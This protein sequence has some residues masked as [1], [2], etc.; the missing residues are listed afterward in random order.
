[1][2]ADDLKQIE[3]AERRQ[4]DVGDQHV[5]FFPIHQRQARLGRGGANDAVVPAQGLR[6]P[7]ARLV[8][9]IDDQYCLSARRHRVEYRTL[10][11]KVESW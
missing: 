9:G 5:H 6:E 4:P 10:E 2:I 3:S 1:M 7:L 11:L 8:V